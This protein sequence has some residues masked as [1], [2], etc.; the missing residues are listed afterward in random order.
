MDKAATSVANPQARIRGAN[1]LFVREFVRSPIRTASVVPSSRALAAMMCRP[2]ELATRSG[3]DGTVVELG[4]GSGAF[5]EQLQRIAGDRIRHIAYELNPAFATHLARRYPAV[6]VI[7][8]D[9]AFLDTTLAD[10]GIEQVDFV[11]SALPWSAYAGMRGPSLVRTVSR[12]LGAQGVF[13]QFTYAWSRWMPPAR[14]Q[15]A[16]L[17]DSFRDVQT[18]RTVWANF[19]PAF[20]YTAS[21]SKLMSG[22]TPWAR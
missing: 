6:E 18:G 21:G 1:A 14:R 13:T 10:R 2:I 16:L 3:R 5:T 7:T 20:V 9:V 4:A 15:H 8:A 11:V 12:I 19:P 17:A 22:R